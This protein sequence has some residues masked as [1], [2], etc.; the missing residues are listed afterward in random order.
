MSRAKKR[1]DRIREEIPIQ[2]VLEDYG[3]QVD[4]GYDGEQQF[5]CD[6][7]GDGNDNKPSARVYPDSSSWYC[8]ACDRSRDA[9]ELVREKEGME[10]WDALKKLEDKY[11]LTPLPWDDDDRSEADARRK[12]KPNVEQEIA[13]ALDPTKTFED[14]RRRVFRLLEGVTTDHDRPFHIVVS[15]WEAFDK[16]CYLVQK[17]QL[18]EKAGREG[19]QR[20]LNKVKG[21]LGAEST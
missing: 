3:Y 2:R 4:A 10:F 19:L 6:L 11:N 8:W 7:H 13:A 14:D 18:A 17:G 21:Q 15:W 5:P 1:A 20:I 9:I 12:P 16:V